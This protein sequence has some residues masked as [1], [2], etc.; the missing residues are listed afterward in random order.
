MG[1]LA[2]RADMKKALKKA[3]SLGAFLMTPLHRPQEVSPLP[4]TSDQ[5]LQ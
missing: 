3:V 4:Q 5:D 2:S 1:W